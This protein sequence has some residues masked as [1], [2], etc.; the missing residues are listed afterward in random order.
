MFRVKLDNDNCVPGQ[1]A[2]KRRHFRL[3]DGWATPA[4]VGH[5]ALAGALSDLAAMGA[6]P[7]EAFIAL[8]LPAGFAERDALAL[9]AAADALAC[10]TGT[11]IAGGDVTAAPAL[12]VT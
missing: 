12:M 4:E 8:G 7:G 5:R 10:E 3:G 6:G 2:G 11:A 1:L 9:V